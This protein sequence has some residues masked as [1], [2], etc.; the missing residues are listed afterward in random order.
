[1]NITD[2]DQTL[3]QQAQAGDT[4]AFDQLVLRYQLRLEKVVANL[5]KNNSDVQDIVQESFIKA[6]RHIQSFRGDSLFYTWLYRIAV[7][8]TKNYLS[9]QMRRISSI[10]LDIEPEDCF[11]REQMVSVEQSPEYYLEGQEAEQQ[12]L[13]AFTS[14]PQA[15]R[16]TLIYREIIGLS[17]Q[18]IADKLQCPIG[19]VRS[20]IARAR[21]LMEHRLTDT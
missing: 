4:M 7:N 14:L 5:L 17:Y 8:T 16:V 10:D 18:A 2:D 6:F 15:M 19:T 3:I 11:D 20:R 13:D 1:M 21:E 9:S 12:I